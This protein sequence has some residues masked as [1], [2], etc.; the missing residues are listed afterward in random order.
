M[1]VGGGE[2]IF[3]Q[4][5]AS[6]GGYSVAGPFDYLPA[7]EDPWDPYTW[8]RTVP[9]ADLET[10]F[11]TIGDDESIEVVE[12]DGRGAFGGRAVRVTV[13]GSEGSSTVSGDTFRSRLGLPS[14]MFRTTD[15]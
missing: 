12:R 11:D 15:L 8:T 5:S 4:F 3:A 9:V 2:P 6:D 14:T 1:L 13:T 7:R 10:A